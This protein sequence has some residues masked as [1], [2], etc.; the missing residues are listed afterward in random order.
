MS[1]NSIRT[2]IWSLLN[3]T[4]FHG[5]CLAILVDKFQKRERIINIFLA[6][7]S[8]GSI[9]A[10]AIWRVEPMIW[11]AIIAISQVIMAIKPYIPYF[12]YV[13]EFN[14]KNSRIDYLNIEIE[15]LW[16]K[17]QNK[18]IT[19]AEAEEI[20]F[21]IKKQIVSILNF[22]DDTVFSITPKIEKKANEKMK[23]FLK[24]NYNMDVN[25]NE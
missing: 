7:V 18:K 9:A 17:Y 25:I 16:Y 5:Y 14:S 21:D 12:K 10:W 22:D 2:Q 15:K 3:N 8:S 19:E 4:K 23:V 6:L 1:D 13:K 11:G 24:N 20:Y